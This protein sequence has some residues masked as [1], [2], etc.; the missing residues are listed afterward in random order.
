MEDFKSHTLSVLHNLTEAIISA[1]DAHSLSNALFNVV[2][3]YVSVE[4][5]AIFLWDFNENRLRMYKSKGF[6]DKDMAYSEKTAMERHPGWVF[7]NRKPL[8]I[9]DMS[10]ED[11]PK[12][13][14]SGKRAYTVQ[15]RLWIPITS[16][17]KSLGSFGFASE[18]TNF[19][20]DEHIKVLELA[21]RIAGNM[22]SQIIFRESEKQYIESIKLSMN[23]IEE[24]NNAQQNFISKMSHEM[25][26]P[27]N[28]IIGISKLLDS[29]KL[30]KDQTEYVDIINSQS[31]ILLNL[32]NDVLDISKIQSDNFKLVQFPF[33]LLNTI[34]VVVNSMK[35]QATQKGINLSLNFDN[36]I[37]KTVLGDYVRLSQVFTN[38]VNNAVKFTDDGDVTVSVN[39]LEKRKGGQTLEIRIKDSGIGIDKKNQKAI[40]ERFKQADE[41][42]SRTYGGSGLGLYI[43]KEIVTKM[44]GEISLNSSPNKGSEFILK[45]LFAKATTTKSE[46]KEISSVDLSNINILVVEDNEV[47]VLYI[48]SILRKRNAN[49]DVARDGIQAIFL[50]ESNKYDLIL[51]DLQMPKLDGISA[52]SHLRKTLS[53][54]TP[55]IAQS[56]NTVQTEIEECY[57]VGVNDFIAKPFSVEQLLSKMLFHLNISDKVQNLKTAPSISSTNKTM[58]ERAL[59]IVEFDEPNAHQILRIFK[60]ESRKDI[61]ILKNGIENN[62]KDIINQTGHKIKSSFR[63]FKMKKAAEISLFFENVND[64]SKEKKEIESNFN[65]LREIIDHCN[66]EIE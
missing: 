9:P 18:Q 63:Y 40:F 44:G 14:T 49:V 62:D 64:L 8:H 35:Y 34:Q 28:G 53:I 36:K 47:N 22:Y 17:D 26:T 42:I 27:L 2:D 24:A 31:N 54:Q 61:E 37:E 1:T 57:K 32:I 60:L 65:Q 5:S 46:N 66:E 3:D 10:K 12:F 41:T 58:F 56:A 21:C 13:V 11:V 48:E 43:T 29:T 52:T 25:R 59:E 23:K 55:I 51:M 39:L 19:F 4:H 16:K 33:D 38:L 30:D 50:C 20:T 6:S 7:K 45:I 15:S